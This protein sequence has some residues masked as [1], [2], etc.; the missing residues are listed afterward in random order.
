MGEEFKGN[1]CILNRFVFFEAALGAGFREGEESRLE[2]GDACAAAFRAV[3]H[4]LYTD[5]CTRLAAL[6]TVAELTD[7][8][9]LGERFGIPMVQ[10]A[11]AKNL[12][13]LLPQLASAELITVLRAAKLYKLHNLNIACR[14]R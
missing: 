1:R 6:A 3:W 12:S 11:C 10:Q 4:Y 5:D 13:S 14:D 9:S 8:L 2:I 7:V